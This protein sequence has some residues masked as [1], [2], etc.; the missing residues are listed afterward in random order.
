M[1][2]IEINL[3]TPAIEMKHIKNMTKENIQGP[4]NM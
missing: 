1:W 3:E 2:G 4:E